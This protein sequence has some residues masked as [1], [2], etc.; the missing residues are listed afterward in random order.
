[1]N[2]KK[3]NKSVKYR[4]HARTHAYDIFIAKPKLSYNG[5]KE[6]NMGEFGSQIKKS[7]NIFFFSSDLTLVYSLSQ[8]FSACMSKADIIC[9]LI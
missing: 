9:V 7:L 8:Y 5:T 3:L 4:A 2:K 1:M 6:W